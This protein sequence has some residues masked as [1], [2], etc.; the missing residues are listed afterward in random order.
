MSCAAP[1]LPVCVILGRGVRERGRKG[2][3]AGRF[4]WRIVVLDPN[5]RCGREMNSP[6]FWPQFLGNSPVIRKQ[7]S[8]P[9][10]SGATFDVT[11]FQG[12]SSVCAASRKVEGGIYFD[13][14]V[15][16]CDFLLCIQPKLFSKWECVCLHFGFF[17]PGVGLELGNW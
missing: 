14:R 3:W 1:L 2:W 12:C 17:W 10:R 5:K 4:C 16:L 9:G 7:F 11:Y 13:M 8:A 15:L 6:F